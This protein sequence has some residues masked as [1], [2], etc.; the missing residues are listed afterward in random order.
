MYADDLRQLASDRNHRVER[1]HRLLENHGNF[2]T[3]NSTHLLALCII[4]QQIFSFKQ[5]LAAHDFARRRLNELH[6]RHLRN[7]FAASGFTANRNDFALVNMV[8]NVIDS[9]YLA[10]GCKKGCSQVLDF[11][12]FFRHHIF[13]LSLGSSASRR[14]SPTTLNAIISTMMHTPGIIASCGALSR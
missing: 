13:P 7:G 9:L 6:N 12:Q 4:I 5:H 11:K 8:R 2:R 10:F 3:A 14:P 1:R